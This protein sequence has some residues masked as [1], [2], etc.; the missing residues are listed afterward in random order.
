MARR[1]LGHSDEDVTDTYLLPSLD[2]VREAVNRAA[3][4]IDGPPEGV[5]DIEEKRRARA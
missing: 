5:P 4:L 1:F 2:A 3:R